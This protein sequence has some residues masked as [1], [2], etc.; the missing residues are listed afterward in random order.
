MEAGPDSGQ[1]S[2]SGSAEGDMSTSL[3]KEKVIFVQVHAK[4]MGYLQLFK[5]T[6][7]AGT[8]QVCRED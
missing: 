3:D 4:R 5:L 6:C 7:A 8:V 2:T 1:S